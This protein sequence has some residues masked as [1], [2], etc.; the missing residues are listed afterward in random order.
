M[1]ASGYWAQSW[2]LLLL[3]PLLPCLHQRLLSCLPTA[4]F[5]CCLLKSRCRLLQL[6]PRHP[7]GWQYG[8]R[9]LQIFCP[10]DQAVDLGRAEREAAIGWIETQKL[11]SLM[12]LLL[13][14]LVV[15]VA[16]VVVIFERQ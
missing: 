14:L 13:L 5:A 12:L 3:L 9:S 15:M 11:P 7:P 2:L 1:D 16:V 6:R 10:L 4:S 8:S